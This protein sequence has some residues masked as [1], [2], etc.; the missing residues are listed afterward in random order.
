LAEL[1]LPSKPGLRVGA[2]ISCPKCQT[3]VSYVQADLRHLAS[4]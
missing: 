4:D 3:V 1:F 2:T